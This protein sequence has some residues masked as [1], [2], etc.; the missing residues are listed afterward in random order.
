MHGD[1]A[2]EVRDMDARAAGSSEGIRLH[3]LAGN[4]A[5]QDGGRGWAAGAP[6]LGVLRLQLSLPPRR[7]SQV[8]LPGRQV[9]PAAAAATLLS[10][11]LNWAVV[12]EG[13][14]ALRQTLQ[15]VSAS[16]KLCE[17]QPT[18]SPP[19]L[20]QAVCRVLALR[21]GNGQRRRQLV[22]LCLQLCQRDLGVPQLAIQG[23]TLP[24][25]KKEGGLLG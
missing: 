19:G 14:A 9:S 2:A 12:T 7:R 17:N 13:H 18:A 1:S 5:P 15:P 23:L 20:P 6:Q 8:F 3:L 10:D 11:T 25:K 21:L 24:C 4:A 16:A 22:P